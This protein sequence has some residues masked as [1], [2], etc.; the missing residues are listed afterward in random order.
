MTPERPSFDELADLDAAVLEPERARELRADPRSAAGL[1]ALAATK[2]DLAAL[3]P[4]PVPADVQARWTAA[5]A[6]AA[7][8]PDPD[9]SKATFT[10]SGDVNVAFLSRAR[11]RARRWRPRPAVAAAV[12]LVAV[13]VAAGV[14][15][16]QSE[17]AGP[18]V[19]AVQLAAA[20]R[21]AMGVGDAGPLADPE[22]RAACLRAVAPDVA[23]DPLI[24][25]RQVQFE[26][27]RG[28]LLVLGT[29]RLGSFRVVVVDAGCEHLLA[30]QLVG[31]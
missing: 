23:P 8:T 11:R 15:R 13:V 9:D 10:S 12:L 25:G 1:D 30:S 7:T 29:G 22:R 26:G 18:Q 19:S 6:A 28:T 27:Q 2:S 20:A 16:A 5:L 14:I 4:V 21:D 17:P 24:G 3:P 31:R